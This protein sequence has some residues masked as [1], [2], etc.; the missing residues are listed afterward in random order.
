M[1]EGSRRERERERKRLI[2]PLLFPSWLVPP[3]YSSGNEFTVVW[4]A[5]SIL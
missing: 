4:S 1:A 5:I 3:S 2:E